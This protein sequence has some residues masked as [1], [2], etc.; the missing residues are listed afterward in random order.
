MIKE[1]I[2]IKAN[3]ENKKH[4]KPNV[5]FIIVLSD[6]GSSINSFF[7]NY[8]NQKSERYVASAFNKIIAILILSSSYPEI[9]IRD[10]IK[11]QPY[12]IKISA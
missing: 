11:L 10:L 2:T 8:K 4:L 12:R 5:F 7:E 1:N 6:I 3:I 9:L